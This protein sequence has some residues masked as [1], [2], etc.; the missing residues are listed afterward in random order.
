MTRFE[1]SESGAESSRRDPRGPPCRREAPSRSPHQPA[2][3]AATAGDRQ[4]R[5]FIGTETSPASGSA[6]SATAARSTSSSR[7]RPRRPQARHPR[8]RR[9]EGH[10]PAP[11]ARRPRSSTASSA[12]W[13]LSLRSRNRTPPSPTSW[14]ARCRAYVKVHCKPKTEKLYRAPPS[15]CTSSPRS[16]AMAVKDV[17]S[18]HVIELH[19]RMRDTPVDGQ[20]RRLDASRR[21]SR[22][23]RPGSWCPGA[24]ILAG[25]SGHYREQSAR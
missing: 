2:A 14:R 19:D 25:W 1:T 17:R 15:T 13:S 8:P 24:A 10:R 20:P 12:D 21:C 18:S 5:P 6:S 11:P 22:S 7:A 4:G 9:R 16:A 23:P 3:V